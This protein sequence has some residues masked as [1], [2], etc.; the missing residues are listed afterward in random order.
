MRYTFPKAEKLK[1]TKALDQ[2]F[3]GGK[4]AKHFP[5]RMVFMPWPTENVPAQ[6]AFSV[7]K[8]RF[9]KAVD[10]NRIKRL[11]RE[12]YRLHKPEY[13]TTLQQQYAIIFIYLHHH[14]IAYA[15]VENCMVQCLKSLKI[16]D[17]S[18]QNKDLPR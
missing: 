16:A 18:I 13:L 1:S 17:Q 3:K 2:L 10:R 14:E 7:S 9:K 12:A 5:I 11:M 15:A 6:A 8:K 4:T